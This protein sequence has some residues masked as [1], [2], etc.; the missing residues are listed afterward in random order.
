MS[1]NDPR[2]ITV[3]CSG[4]CTKCDAP[5]KKGERAF[6]YP[7]G[8]MLLGSACGHGEEAQRDFDAAVAD[9]KNCVW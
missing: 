2:W 4:A 1:K 3:K 8:R 5:I 9:E 6:Y 7:I